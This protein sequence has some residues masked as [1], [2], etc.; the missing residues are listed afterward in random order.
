MTKVVN[1]YREKYDQYIGRGSIWGNP[2]IL[3]DGVTRDEV[4]DNFTGYFYT[5]LLEDEEFLKQTLALKGKTL[6]CFCKPKKCHGDVIAN[7]LNEFH[8]RLV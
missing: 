1:K 7:F 8:S 2:F 4:I 6:G 3:E 5:R